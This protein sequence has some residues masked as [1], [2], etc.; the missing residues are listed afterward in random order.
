MAALKPSRVRLALGAG[1]LALLI[2]GVNF[3]ALVLVEARNLIPRGMLLIGVVRHVLSWQ[4]LGEMLAVQF[5][6]T[7]SI[8]LLAL[9]FRHESRSRPD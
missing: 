9:A 4:I 8:F 7:L 2:T 6:A 1:I 3:L 5:A